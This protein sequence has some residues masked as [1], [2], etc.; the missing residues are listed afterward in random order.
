[1]L[2]IITGCIQ[3]AKD[4]PYVAIRDT[5]ERLHDYLETIRWAIEET[6]F[7]DILFG[8]NSNYQL[9]ALDEIHKLFA[10]SKTR[11]KH[12][13][14]YSFQGNGLEVRLKGKGYGE[15]E[16]IAWL[17]ENSPTM[18]KYEYYYKI[19]GRLTIQNI[20]KVQLSN[21]AEN[22]FIFDIGMRSVDT[23][24]YKMKMKDYE[25]FFKKAYQ[26][27]NDSENR[28]LEYVYFSTLTRHHLP[29]GRFNRSLEFRGKS[30]SSGTEYRDNYH[31]NCIFELFYKSFLYRTYWGRELL[32]YVRR[33][34][35]R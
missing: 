5:E 12:F 31:E 19:T 29:F 17:Y 33:I 18:R 27:V 13:S 15:G 6:P 11:G 26:E 23:R 25:N 1:M 35:V 8:D 32:K 16:I 21:K 3:V 4:T 34:K 30:G 10:L 22:L 28:V 24:F 2:L 14:Y 9:D 20:H 7:T